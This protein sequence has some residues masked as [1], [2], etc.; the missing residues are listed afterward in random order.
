MLSLFRPVRRR[1]VLVVLLMLSASSWAT[2]P[3]VRHPA[4]TCEVLSSPPPG[5][6]SSSGPPRVFYFFKY[7][8][9]R[10]A[11]ATQFV[12]E[13]EKKGRVTIERVYANWG[14]DDSLNEHQYKRWHYAFRTL[15]R[16]KEITPK[17]FESVAK[18]AFKRPEDL[19][20]ALVSFSLSNGLT[21]TEL[22]SAF[23][24]SA[25][26]DELQYSELVTKNH[27]VDQVPYITFNGKYRIRWKSS[28]QEASEALGQLLEEL[29]RR[30]GTGQ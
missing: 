2:C 23:D 17:L 28:E 22:R 8:C 19:I 25:T 10:C 3:Q 26:K 20:D 30:E 27:D 14:K 9:Q 4:V 15:G 12:N 18:I 16:E 11:N 29:T 6:Q 5:S 24:S 21:K 1:V 13:W 7:S